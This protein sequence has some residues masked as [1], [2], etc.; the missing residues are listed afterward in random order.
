MNKVGRIFIIKN[1]SFN[2]KKFPYSSLF[3]STTGGINHKASS[4]ALCL[5][6]PHSLTGNFDPMATESVTII[7]VTHA[8]S[9]LH[10]SPSIE[11][12]PSTVSR[13]PDVTPEAEEGEGWLNRM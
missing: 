7:H 12:V 10:I 2:G 6:Q 8:R 3:P 13:M 4:V 9:P 11:P 5:P 1:V